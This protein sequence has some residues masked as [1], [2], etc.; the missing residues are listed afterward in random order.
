MGKG[1]IAFLIWEWGPLGG[2][3][4]CKQCGA[5][6]DGEDLTTCGDP[7]DCLS[8]PLAFYECPKCGGDDIEQ[9]EC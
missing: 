1:V 5:H 6:F 8:D 9:Q 4:Q 3:F 2:W 7:A